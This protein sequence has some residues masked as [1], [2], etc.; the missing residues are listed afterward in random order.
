MARDAHRPGTSW[1]HQAVLVRTNA[2]LSLFEEAFAAAGIPFRSRGGA[3]FL[4]QPEIKDVI[5]AF[6]RGGGSVSSRLADQNFGRACRRRL[7]GWMVSLRRA[8][9]PTRHSSRA[10]G[11]KFLFLVAEMRWPFL[12]S[13]LDQLGCHAGS[14]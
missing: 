5:G 2:Q 3:R 11:Q 10:N 8:T 14:C 12:C 6:R 7:F 4:D 9:I 1:S 13:L